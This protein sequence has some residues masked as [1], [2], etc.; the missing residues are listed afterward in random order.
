MNF[1]EVSVISED[2]IAILSYFLSSGVFCITFRG[3]YGDVVK[4]ECDTWIKE[5]FIL[6]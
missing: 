6:L 5:V 2:V 4:S 1:N 3:K